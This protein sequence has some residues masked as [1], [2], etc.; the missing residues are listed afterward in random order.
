ML[1]PVCKATCRIA[2]TKLVSDKGSTDVY[3]EQVIVC[4]N[5]GKRL[6]PDGTYEKYGEPCTM[7]CEDMSNPTKVVQV[8]KEK[9]N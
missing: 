3:C 6:K 9:V 2:S 5:S 8:I 1:C 4:N 7:Y